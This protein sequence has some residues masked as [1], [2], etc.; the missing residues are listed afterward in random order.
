[1]TKDARERFAGGIAEFPARMLK[2]VE[3]QMKLRLKAPVAAR[4]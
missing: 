2:A 1:M 4:N 3:Q